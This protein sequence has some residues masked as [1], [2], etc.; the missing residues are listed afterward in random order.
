MKRYWKTISICLVTLIVLGTFYIQSSFAR[1]EHISIEFEK[2]HGNEDEV[3]NLILHGDYYAD[4]LYQPLQITNEETIDPYNLSFIQKMS[5][6]GV[7]YLLEELVEK[8]KN[9]MRS[10]DLTPT[11][12]FEDENLVAYASIKAKN[13]VHPMKDL[14]FDIEVLNKKSEEVSSIQLDVPDKENYGWM[15][16]EDVQVIEGELKVITRGSRINSGDE[17]RVYTFDMK[18]QK[19]LTDNAIASIPL[20]KN[21]WSDL[22]IINDYNSIQRNKYLLIK[23]ET[24]EDEMGHSDGETNIVAN[25][26]IVYDIENNQFNKIVEPAEILESISGDSAIFNSTIFIP[27]Q[28]AN[29]LEVNQYDIENEK[30]DK[31]LT[32]D[33]VD[34]KNE[35]SPYIKVMNGKL[36]AI[37]LTNN[38]HSIFI[39]DLKTGESL[40]EGKLKMKNQGENQK[41]FRL[42]FHEIEYVQ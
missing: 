22:R 3:K 37:H 6:M 12:F 31:K 19:L 25:E 42:Y 41:D 15:Q 40:Y 20:V 5:G 27:S 14:T 39:G 1:N 9:F 21:G 4:H 17:L 34:T 30:W 18:E 10:K 28:S 8:H 33:I 24:S 13:H 11:Q 36:Y 16:V 2:V 29:G 38:G 26:F 23:I 7:P 32:F 35:E